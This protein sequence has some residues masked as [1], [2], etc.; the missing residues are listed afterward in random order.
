M[1]EGDDGLLKRSP[2]EYFLIG[3]THFNT[4]LENVEEHMFGFIRYISGSDHFFK[5][6]FL[7]F[8]IFCFTIHMTNLTDK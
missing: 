7:L 1:Q 2:L 4:H 6:K 3:E 5:N 8:S